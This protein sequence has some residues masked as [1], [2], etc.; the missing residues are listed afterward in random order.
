[1]EYKII[2]NSRKMQIVLATPPWTKGGKQIESLVRKA[3]HQFDL[4]EQKEKIGI[5]LSGGK[6]SITLLFL[7]KAISG[8]GF[9]PFSLHA[10]HVAGAFSCGASVANNYLKNLCDALQVPLTILESTQTLETLEC[11]SCTRE[12][13][14]LLFSAAKKEGIDTIA[15][16]HHRD[17]HI[18]TLLMNLCQ[19][20]DF[21]GM[22]PK[23]EMIKYGVTIIRPLFFVGEQEILEFSKHYQ[24]ARFVCQCPVGQTSKRRTAKELLVEIEEHF[25][26]CRDN[27]TKASLL[28]G[29]KSALKQ[30]EKLPI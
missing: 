1:M 29:G 14:K 5:A 23:I 6:D 11:Y 13:R 28:F 27:L 9:P 24:F 10:F 8:R 17:D 15:F 30:G 22:H 3:L 12:R 26:S 18:E 2:K 7:L 25:P 16:G 20:G 19:K 21:E 4:V